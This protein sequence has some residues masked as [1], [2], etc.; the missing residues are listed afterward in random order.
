MSVWSDGDY[1]EILTQL[2]PRAF[3][4]WQGGATPG[5][6]AEVGG[7][8]PVLVSAQATHVPVTI[9]EAEGLD[10]ALLVGWWTS[11]PTSHVARSRDGGAT[12]SEL[13]L[14]TEPVPY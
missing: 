7:A 9:R 11:G 12:W 2:G 1:Q 13:A 4:Y 8:A 14:A 10:G 3:A 5:V 6:Y